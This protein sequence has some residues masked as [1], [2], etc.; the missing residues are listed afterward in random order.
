M[1]RK[2]L[3]GYNSVKNVG[4]VSIPVLCIS[5]DN[6]LYLYKFHQ[7]ILKGIRVM[8]NLGT[9][10]WTDGG[11][12]IIRPILDSRIK[13]TGISSDISVTSA[14]HFRLMV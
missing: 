3:K 4:G 2:I 5:S 13:R 14:Q 12:D 7:N 9:D 11:H 8:E 6:G 10:R 1:I